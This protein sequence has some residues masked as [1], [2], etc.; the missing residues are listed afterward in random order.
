MPIELYAF[1][2]DSLIHWMMLKDF[3]NFHLVFMVKLSR[4]WAFGAHHL[5]SYRP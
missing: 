5:A 2:A 3:E 1:I 4:C